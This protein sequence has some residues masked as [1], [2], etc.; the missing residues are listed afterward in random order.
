MN[1]HPDHTPPKK[2]SRIPLPP[3]TATATAPVSTDGHRRPLSETLL[4]SGSS[5]AGPARRK[6]NSSLR[7]WSARHPWLHRLAIVSVVLACLGAISG[8]TVFAHYYQKASAFDLAEMSRIE[9]GSLAVDR[10]DQRIGRISLQDRRLVS[11]DE[12][13]QHLIDALVATEDSRF[14]DHGGYDLRGIARAAVANLKA[15]GIRQGG[16]TITQQLARHA[17]SL[18]GRNFDRKFTELFL[19]CRIEQAYSKKVILEHYLNRI[20]LGCGYW[21]VGSASIGYFGKEVGELTPDESAMLCAIIKSPNRFSPFVDASAAL[22]ARDRTLARMVNLEFIDSATC[23]SLMDEPCKALDDENQLG[24]PQYL[25]AQLRSEALEILGRQRALDGY[26]I[27]TAVDL[28]V[29]QQLTDTINRKLRELEAQPD[30][31]HQTLA[32]Y[33]RESTDSD[34]TAPRYIQAAAVVLENKTGRILSTIGGR[35]FSESQFNRVLQARR[36]PGSAFFPLVYGAA[37]ETGAMQP[38]ELIVDAPVDN[39][40]VMVGG[41]EGVLGEWSTENPAARYEG[42]ITA[43]YALVTSKNG[44]T[45]KVGNA[46]GL[47]EVKKLAERSGITA[48]LRDFPNTFIGVSEVSLLD[49]V[50]SYT[51]FPNLGRH[52]GKPYLITRILSPAG[53]VVYDSASL[54]G[55]NQWILTDNTAATINGLLKASFSAGPAREF[56]SYASA[57]EG[58]I[59]GKNGTSYDFEDNWFVGYNADYTWGVWVGFDQPTPIATPSFSKDTALPIWLSVARHLDPGR[60]FDNANGWRNETHC[61][62]SGKRAAAGCAHTARGDLTFD[63]PVTR[64]TAAAEEVCPLHATPSDSP[65]GDPSSRRP[66]S[67]TSIFYQ[68]V[69]AVRPEIPVLTGNDPY[70]VLASG[71]PRV[72]EKLRQ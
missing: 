4:A 51:A 46:A 54:R 32:G 27:E 13:P 64:E 55:P 53:E 66:P 9:A 40:K 17:Y 65:E 28:R 68:D 63:L 45:V 42:E 48:P 69:K 43:G 22:A 52:A 12:V 26:T 15:G 14:F 72:E 71:Q 41:T 31:P 7:N 21:G 2:T 25:L 1:P 70:G 20:Y 3:A 44:A 34:T 11:I 67:L 59:A 23:A 47:D 24:R 6:S 57:L 61:L 36:P 5:S 30:Y 29:Q 19:A 50:S 37:F 8:A 35:D 56:A 39:R 62:L 38:T 49:L 60:P 33:S 58:D 18:G 10:H 16:S